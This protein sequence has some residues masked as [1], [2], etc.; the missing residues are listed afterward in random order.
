MAQN[1]IVSLL[2]EQISVSLIRRRGRCG[3]GDFALRAP[4]IH[5]IMPFPT[6]AATDRPGPSP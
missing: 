6:F 1:I 2:G 4:R 5:G 3:F